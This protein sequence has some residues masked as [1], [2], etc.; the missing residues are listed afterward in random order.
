MCWS[1]STRACTAAA[2]SRW[3]RRWPWPAAWPTCPASQ[4]QGITGYEGALV[5]DEP[6]PDRRAELARGARDYFAATA[7]LLAGNG[8][9]CEIITAAGTANWEFDA[10][11]PR[12]TEI[13]PGSYATMDGFHRTLETRFEHAT[14]VLA[15]CVSRRSNRFIID[16]GGK[17]VGASGALVKGSPLPAGRFEEEHGIF[18]RDD[19]AFPIAVGDRVELLCAYTPFAVGYFD[20]Y[21]VVENDRVVDI[22]PVMP[23]G[24]ESRWLLDMLERGQ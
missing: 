23:R 17:T 16:A 1:R 24:P 18:V 6:D 13:Q 20:A 4:F 5:T 12:L 22:W 21:H 3:R 8:L 11:D 2:R 14:T 7:D 9:P 15:T 10:A 19:A